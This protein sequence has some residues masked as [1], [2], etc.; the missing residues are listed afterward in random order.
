MI[1]EIMEGSGDSKDADSDYTDDP[2]ALA[3]KIF[4]LVHIDDRSSDRE[5]E[6]TDKGTDGDRDGSEPDKEN[7]EQKVRLQSFL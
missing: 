7:S 6:P 5:Y 2:S 1:P 3:M 4:D